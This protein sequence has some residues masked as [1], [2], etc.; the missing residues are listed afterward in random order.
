[1]TGK[2]A[3]IPDELRAAWEQYIEEPVAF[4]KRG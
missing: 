4:A 3:R 1:A 2:P